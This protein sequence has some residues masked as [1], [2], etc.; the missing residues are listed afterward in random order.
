MTDCN[1]CRDLQVTS[2]IR[3]PD[4]LRVMIRVIQ[5][6]LTSGILIEETSQPEHEREP[7]PDTFSAIEKGPWPDFID[8]R[9]KCTSCHQQF[10]LEVETYHGQGGKWRPL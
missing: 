3:V 6:N 10:Q 7:T 2:R 1:Q 8:C 4:D 9:F 5:E